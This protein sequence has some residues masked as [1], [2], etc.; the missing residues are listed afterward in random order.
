VRG[1]TVGVFK[2]QQETQDVNVNY[3]MDTPLSGV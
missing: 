3:A 2:P 1:I